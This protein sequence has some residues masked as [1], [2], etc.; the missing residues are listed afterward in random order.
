MQYFSAYGDHY[1][2]GFQHGKH[3]SDEIRMSF[4]KHCQFSAPVDQVLAICKDM[5][6]K[7]KSA[8]PYAS[9]ELKGIA[10]GCGIPYEE[11]LMLNS[12]DDIEQV[13]SENGQS[14]CTSITFRNTEAGTI[15][16]KTTDIEVFQKKDY[17]LLEVFPSDG[18]HCFLLGKIGTLKC[19]A[20]MN[21]RGLCIGTNS[22]IEK[23]ND[24]GSIDRMTLIRY[25]LEKCWDID[26]ALQM[27]RENPFYR[28]GLNVTIIDSSGKAVVAECGNTGL[29]VRPI[30]DSVGFAT[31]HYLTPSMEPKY[32]YGIWYYRNSLKRF[33]Y[34]EQRYADRNAIRSVDEMKDVIQSHANGGC[35][36][37][38]EKDCETTFATIWIPR[39]RAV[40]VCDG[41]PCENRFI[42]WHMQNDS[43]TTQ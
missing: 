4:S 3:F 24:L 6:K 7:L 5:D 16:G 34:L 32:D 8:L 35:I 10:D 15:L 33:S 36:C 42:L 21:S 31:N 38:H 23:N 25:V 27:L 40:W 39:E 43:T 37:N 2:I 41:Q 1:H 19:E 22:A 20:G 17:Y 11:A 26:S 29:G 30:T 13:L 18:F 12:W 9:E 14:L 28:L